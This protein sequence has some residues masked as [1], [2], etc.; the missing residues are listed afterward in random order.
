MPNVEEIDVVSC[1]NRTTPLGYG[2]RYPKYMLRDDRSTDF[3]YLMKQ[4]QVG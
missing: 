2:V 3:F 4:E 1:K